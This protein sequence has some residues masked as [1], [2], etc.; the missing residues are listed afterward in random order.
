MDNQW[1]S[2]ANV[3]QRAGRAGRVQPGESYHLYTEEKHAE[4]EPFPLAEILRIPLEK[5][6]MDIKAYDGNLKAVEFLSRA[7]EP[8]SRRAIHSAIEELWDIG[9]LDGNEQLTALGR[10]IALF[11]THPRLSKALVYATLFR[12]LDPVASIVAGLSS[13]REG[14]SVDSSVENARM[15]LRLAKRQFHKSSD[16]LALANLL[17]RFCQLR[18]RQEVDD[19]CYRA[20]ANPKALHFLKGKLK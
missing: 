16:H 4:L 17:N 13:S 14:W 18:G 5:V 19:Y 12:C 7:L 9:A 1:I 3:Q 6:I 11:S 10:R 15:V 8:P 20:R 2:K